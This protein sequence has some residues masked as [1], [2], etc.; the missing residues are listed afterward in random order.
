MGSVA[1][2]LLI[3][4]TLVGCTTPPPSAYVGDRNGP[5]A[6]AA[7]GLGPNASGEGCSQLPGGAPG[8]VNIYCGDWKQPS[9]HVRSGGPVPA[10][11]LS[12]LAT[13]SEWRAG[14]DLRYA[15]GDPVPT[16]VLGNEPALL[17][18]CTRRVGG[19]PQVALVAAVG[20]QAWLADGILPAL[21]IMERSIGVL[22]NRVSADA[23]TLPQSAADTLLANQLAARAFSAGDVG[24]YEQAMALG[25]RANL[26][27]NFSAAE[28]AYR[29]ALALQQKA[30]G[31]DNPDTVTPLMHLA[32]Q[33]SNQGHFAAADSLF[34]QAD[35][36]APRATDRAATARLLHYRALDAVNRGRFDEG[37]ALI[38]RAEQ[39]YQ[40][41]IP[42]DV[43]ASGQGRV[44]FASLAEGTGPSGAIGDL[45]PNGRL[46]VDPGLQSALMGVI[47]ARRY[48]AIML[49]SKGQAVESAAAI[50]S[51]RTLAQANGMVMPLIS[52]RLLRTEGTTADAAGDLSSADTSL[53]QSA[54]D[55]GQVLPYTRPL[56]QTALLRA[57]EY[58][59]QGRTDRAL[60]MCETGTKLL[61]DLRAGTEASLLS[62]CLSAYA[63]EAQRRPGE[64]QSLFAA[65]F[66]TAELMQDSVTSRQITEAAAR[67][68]AQA[69]DP[70]VSEAIRRR[71]D[72]AETLAELYRAR[73]AVA[74]PP[75]PGSPP[76]SATDRN[77]AD[78]DKR[79]ASSQADLADADGALQ[80]AS[81]NYGQ[82]VQEVVP[83][84]AVLSALAP[85]EAFVAIT[86]IRDTSRRESAG[87]G[88][89]FLLRDG[90]IS[91]APVR[92]DL[93]RITELVR[94]V[95]ASLEP[96]ASGLPRFDTQAAQAIYQAVLDPVAEPLAGATS[97]VVAPFGPLLSVP[98]GLLLTGPG[99]PSHLADAPWLIRRMTIT[100]VP[101]AVN[102]VALRRTASGSRAA[103]P[104]FGFGDPRPVTLRQAERTF[105]SADC[106]NSARL[107]AGL[108]RLPY[109]ERELDGAR[110]ILGAPR[111]DALLGTAFTAANVT[112]TRLKDYRILHF[113]THA[114]LPTELRCQ[115]EP[116]IVT[117]DPAG[118]ADAAG[119]LLTATAI[120]G[121]D[122][123][124][125]AV[126]LSACNSGGPNETTAGDSLSGL[127][128]AF[129]Y[130]GARAMMVTHWSINDQSSA[131]LVVDTLHRYDKGNAG[132]LAG[133][134]ADA[135]RDM[136]DNAGKTL[137]AELAHP[138]YWAP[139]AL[140]GEGSRPPGAAMRV[141]S[142]F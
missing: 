24:Q 76:I 114:L 31:R 56:A 58:A 4:C 16:T 32:L 107:F 9:A 124:A 109:G 131:Y 2:T 41:L 21:P 30:I 44:Q 23:T 61:R 139:F 127:A 28:V 118:A 35:A 87:G 36:M 60:R 140:I 142:G 59:R 130:A 101:A 93:G 92:A 78:L 20:G 84:S 17:L 49:R 120:V 62:P 104:W 42:P 123:D 11:G 43:L 51:A 45:L 57:A 137:P 26:A 121:M 141:T 70:R 132:G 94:K 79:I 122:L 112:R 67:L 82:L 90:A 18:R 12:T 97:L 73:D 113:A 19:W 55:F 95:R 135:Q 52:A 37:L 81:P 91:A 47:E 48:R 6:G 63:A 50:S 68:A 133:A 53:A 98:F 69:H 5:Q 128:R 66:E 72:A 117:S 138:F 46:M 74:Q 40:A 8:L 3:L 99:D 83:A 1:K 105:P 119:A 64:R 125:D 39:A 106:A 33:V 100:H 116:A 129:F 85:G 86:L 77:P 71:Q 96:G 88:W 29:A 89:V 65:M 34:R 75:T 111:S 13:A 134:L 10:G 108:P 136:L 110:Q 126:I 115:T 38:G 25:A 27:E 22:S 15:C 54:A 14:L 80:E 102:F 7:V 103:H